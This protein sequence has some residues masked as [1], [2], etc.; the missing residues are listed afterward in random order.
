MPSPEDVVLNE[1]NNVMDKVVDRIFQ[2]S[3][4]RLIEDNKIDT[5]TLL[6][7]ANVNRKFLDKE[8][9]YFFSYSVIF[10]FTFF[11]T[12]PGRFIRTLST[13]FLN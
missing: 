13:A 6:K 5:G 8:I 9:T 3:Q 7:T 1:I 11:E 10:S 4:E 12:L 2:L